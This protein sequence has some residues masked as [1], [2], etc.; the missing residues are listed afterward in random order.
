LFGFIKLGQL[1]A[2]RINNIMTDE[3][4]DQLV[5]GIFH[6]LVSVTCIYCLL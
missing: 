4:S 2:K 5:L 3:Q 1:K 6:L